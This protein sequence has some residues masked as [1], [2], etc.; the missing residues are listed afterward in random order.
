MLRGFQRL[1]FPSKAPSNLYERSLLIL[2]C[3]RKHR[4][5]RICLNL[6]GVM[7]YELQA[8]R[9]CLTI[10]NPPPCKNIPHE[11]QQVAC[12]KRLTDRSRQSQDGLSVPVPFSLH[13]KQWLLQLLAAYTRIQV[14]LHLVTSSKT[15]C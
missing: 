11:S 15:K 7:L 14:Y 2:Y 9:V 5:E 4:D 3:N 6:M 13:T 12:S 1:I 10:C 8:C